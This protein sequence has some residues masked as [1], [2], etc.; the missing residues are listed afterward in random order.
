VVDNFEHELVVLGIRIKKFRVLK[1]LTQTE[2]AA[3]CDID[4]R[5]IQRIEKGNNNFSIKILFAICK[6]LEIEPS[7][8]INP[9]SII[10]RLI[11]NNLV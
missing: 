10:N 4:I 5:T 6:T 9:S 2:L 3:K 8:I 11:V 1:K 7:E